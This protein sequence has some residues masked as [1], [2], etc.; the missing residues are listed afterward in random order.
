MSRVRTAVIGVGYLGRFHAQKYAAM[1]DVDLVGVVDID[2]SRAREVAHEV[3]T[4]PLSR[5]GDLPEDIDAVSIAVPTTAH[6]E[7][8]IPLLERGVAVL[9]EKPISARL[10]EARAII[11]AA[12]RAAQS[13]RSDISNGSTRRCSSSRAASKTPCSS[14]PTG[15]VRSRFAAP[16]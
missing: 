7:V 10:D 11:D 3:G 6:A 9:L 5:C 8:A 15:S 12:A 4:R 16:M 13:S 14:R 2:A 1:D